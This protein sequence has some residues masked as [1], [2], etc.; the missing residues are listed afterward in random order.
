MKK[1]YII[2]LMIGLISLQ[3]FAQISVRGKVIDNTNEPIIGATVSIKGAT[4]GT[5]TDIN[6]NYTIKTEE[7]STLLFSFLG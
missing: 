3:T 4:I 7:G 5:I 1:I 6:G 2:L